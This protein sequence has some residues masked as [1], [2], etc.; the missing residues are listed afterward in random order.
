MTMTTR[1]NPEERSKNPA[2]KSSKYRDLKD[3]CVYRNQ[4]KEFNK[5]QVIVIKE[6]SC[7]L[8]YLLVL[9]LVDHFGSA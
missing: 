9:V 4:V 6:E 8:V 1:E 3:G 2:P 7:L 5:G